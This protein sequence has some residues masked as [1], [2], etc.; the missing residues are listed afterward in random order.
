[1][2]SRRHLV[3][4]EQG[5]QG[6]VR[7]LRRGADGRIVGDVAV[8]H[9][10]LRQLIGID[11]LDVPQ[12]PGDRHHVDGGIAAADAD[13]LVGSD[14]HAALVEGL[15]EGDAR[16]AVGGAGP[17]R[18][19]Q[20]AAAL[21]PNGPQNGVVV[22]LQGLDADVLANLGVQLDLD[23]AHIQ[24]ALDLGIELV[25]GHAVAWDTELEHAAEPDVGLED[26]A[27]VALA[28]Q[29]IGRGQAGGPAA[30][31]GD[32]LAAVRSGDEPVAVGDG[33][34]ADE[35]LDGVDPD[36][37]LDLVAV[38]AVLTGGRADP[39]HHGREGIGIGG[40][41]EGIFLPGRPGWRQLLLAD[42]GKPAAD[43]LTRG[44][45]P[46]TGR[47]LVDIGR[48][49]VG[50]V[51]DEDLLRQGLP[52]GVAVLVAPPRKLGVGVVAGSR[53]GSLSLPVNRSMW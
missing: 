2:L 8:V 46:L 38:A 33:G 48:A 19:R 18:H 21:A 16:Y 4:G 50:G 41:A 43:V 28:A 32:A 45:A 23:L 25:A 14:L 26:G 22:L 30:D 1:M 29:L 20:A 5:G 35:L 17:A 15:E 9:H 42:D 27:G 13:D 10:G 34:V 36:E 6:D 52:L 53:H 40:A 12:A 51:L 37:I 39:A 7:A 31:D 11:V 24:D 44:T 49:L 3:A 47:G